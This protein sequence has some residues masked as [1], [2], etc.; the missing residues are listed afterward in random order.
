MFGRSLELEVDFVWWLVRITRGI[1]KYLR[2][3]D[4]VWQGRRLTVDFQTLVKRGTS[5]I[6]ILNF[7]EKKLFESQ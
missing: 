2:V 7:S 3:I 5:R 1:F 6:L 4:D